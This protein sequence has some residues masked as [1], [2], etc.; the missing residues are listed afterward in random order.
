MIFQ[1]FP[2]LEKS[3]FLDANTHSFSIPLIP[4]SVN[5]YKRPRLNQ[6]L[7][8]GFYKT[9]EA[10]AFIDA[11]CMLSGRQPIAGEYFSVEMEFYLH[12]SDFL[13]CDVDNF[14]KVCCDALTDAGLIPD[15]RYI[16][17]LTLTK[18]RARDAQDV[19]TVYLVRGR[20]QL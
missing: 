17:D 13:R 19:R 2:L 4:P 15:D 12:S 14:S 10:Q 3:I 9:A 18:R 7:T 1:V 20:E 8:R 5:H 16:T 11:V 6:D